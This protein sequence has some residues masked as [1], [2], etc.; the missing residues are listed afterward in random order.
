MDWDPSSYTY[1]DL[2]REHVSRLEE[3][4]KSLQQIRN[5]TSTLQLF[6]RAI[7]RHDG[8][9][10]SEDFSALFED[11]I[12]DFHTWS[13]TQ[14]VS[15]ATIANRLSCLRAI[16]ETV[17]FINGNVVTSSSFGDILKSLMASK[18]IGVTELSKKAGVNRKK[19]SCWLRGVLPN[20]KS[21]N[22]LGRLEKFFQLSNRLLQR[23]AI[24]ILS[25]LADGKEQM[26]WKNQSLSRDPYLYKTPSP[27][28]FQEWTDLVHFYTSPYLIGGLKR[29]T[30]WRTKNLSRITRKARWEGKADTG[31]CP[32]A[33]MRWRYFGALFGYL[34]LDSSRG[35]KSFSDSDITIAL[36]SDARLVLEYIEFRRSRSGMY[37][38]EIESVISFFLSL[39]REET[40]YLWQR[41]EYGLRLKKPVDASKWHLWCKQ[42]S[43]LLRGV[44]KDLIKGGH[45]KIGRDPKVPI[46]NILSMQHPIMA[47]LNM[48]K[49]MERQASLNYGK[50]SNGVIRRDILLI[51]M[52]V[53]NPLRVYHF[54]IM[55]YRKDNTGNLYQDESGEWRLRF[56]PEDFKNQRGAANQ[57]YDVALSKWL[58]ED[59]Y[60]Y[61]N[62]YRKF[63][64]AND[65]SDHLFLPGRGIRKNA[66]IWNSQCI[67]ERIKRITR[68]YIPNCLG[69]H[70]HAFRHIV[71]TDFIKNNPNG[72][73]IV[74]NILHDKLE[75]V[76]KEYA[77]IK[78]AD[79]FSHWTNYFDAQVEASKGV[80]HE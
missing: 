47:I 19:V 13:S 31:Y 26:R 30:T 63:L 16:R 72:Y 69:F 77:H 46:Q 12:V 55:T 33:E 59:I 34:L 25:I 71:A 20:E 14:G 21:L 24:E 62:V 4:Q 48:I 28:V 27:Q 36:A 50:Y 6:M 79:G 15:S 64:Y 43:E 68:R 11:R 40:G 53:S 66:E 75:T 78:V 70:A 41:V 17:S 9:D 57:E 10:Y 1:A 58:Y 80:K 38:G 8:D 61:I 35:G 56:L 32:T 42:N 5:H 37:T 67:S 23:K 51:K 73:Q 18:G 60:Q 76:M 3:E 29:N 65:T 45:I 2:R 74:A 49:R 7:G 44:L 39:L 22:D 54:S 52:M